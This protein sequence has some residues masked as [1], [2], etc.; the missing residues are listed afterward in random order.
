MN[1]KLA[2]E[3]KELDIRTKLQEFENLKQEM[4]IMK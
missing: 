1:D 3:E 4:N 2:A